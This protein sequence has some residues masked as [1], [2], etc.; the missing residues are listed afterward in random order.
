[1]DKE[2][3]EALSE[4]P[5]EGRLEEPIFPISQLGET[6]PEHDPTGRFKN[7]L[8]TTQAAIR[9]GAGTIQIVL[10]TPPESA[11]GGRPKAYGEEVRQALKEVAM[12]SNVNIAGVELPTALNNLAGFDYQQLVFSDE[13]RK[14]SLDEVRDAIRFVADIGRGGGVDI[15]SWEFPR[16]VNEASWQ[17]TDPEKKIFK[18]EGEQR[19]GWLVDRRSGRTVQFRKDEIQH[20]P[21]DKKAFMPIKVDPSTLERPTE[22]KLNAFEWEDFERW[23]QHNQD[24][25]RRSIG[26][27]EDQPETAEEIYVRVQLEGQIKSLEGWRTTYADRANDMQQLMR[28][29][30]EREGLAENAEQKQKHQQEYSR[31]KAQYAD[32][33]NSAHGQL[34]QAT[35]LRERRRH[36]KPIKDYA[37]KRSM[38][39]YAEAGVAAMQEYEV[40]RERGT[41]TKPLYVGPEIGWPGYYGSHPD[42][43]IELVKGAR[44]QMVTLLTKKKISV[45]HP[46]KGEVMDDNP[47]YNSSVS[48]EQARELANKHVKGLFDTSHM[49]MW[50]AHFKPKLGETEDQRIERFNK[51]F[52]LPAV[53]KI[54]DA[55]IVG[56]VQLV[57]SKSAAHGHLPPGQGIFPIREA[58]QIM[59]DK[60][61]SGFIVS[62]GHEEE[63]FGEGRIR[64]KTW[65]MAGAPVGAGYFSGPPLQ[66]QQVQHGYFGRTYS[67]QF[68][69]GGYSPSNEFKLWSEVPLE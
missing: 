42:E 14:Q 41:I 58:A 20:I 16:S 18:Q 68:M 29:A 34:Q 11:I 2:Y 6:V 56:G 61:F 31:V 27:R 13:K 60:Q 24:L 7:I 40:G 47:Y 52:Y 39:T 30:K 35:E 48:T 57:D 36:L 1:M 21:Y 62:E 67:P 53:R 28:Q 10:Q 9:G 64:M 66:W 3:H 17:P 46:T 43:F 4:T 26:T 45:P 50:L 49:G 51:E 55:G 22:M 32:Y 37:L 15:V 54:F 38:R 44:D 33:L 63:K 5:E 19:I 65:Q 25:N 8:Q 59:K 69:F 23:A 12:A